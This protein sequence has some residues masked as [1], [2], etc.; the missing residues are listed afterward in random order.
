MSGFFIIRIFSNISNLILCWVGFRA[1][2]YKAPVYARVF[3]L[4]NIFEQLAEMLIWVSAKQPGRQ[5]MANNASVIAEIIVYSY[6]FYWIIYSKI[7]RWIFIFLNFLI[8]FRC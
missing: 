3:L 4:L 5:A 1:F 7:I 6:I 2:K 8:V